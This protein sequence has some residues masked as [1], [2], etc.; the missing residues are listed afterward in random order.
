MQHLAP[1]N[2]QYTQVTICLTRSLWGPSI[3]SKK[4]PIVSS[5]EHVV[6]SCLLNHS[7]SFSLMHVQPSDGAHI[8]WLQRLLYWDVAAAVSSEKTPGSSSTEQNGSRSL[9]SSTILHCLKFLEPR[10][11]L[12][13]ANRGPVY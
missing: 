4:R 10:R 1:N 9:S 11:I 5:F 2:I 6:I 8:L 12:R 7:I 13:D 3:Q